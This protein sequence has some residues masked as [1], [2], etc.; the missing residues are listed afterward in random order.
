MV[1][2]F[3]T[4]FIREV[5]RQCLPFRPLIR[6]VEASE[7]KSIQRTVCFRF[8]IYDLTAKKKVQNVSKWH[9]Y[10]C[11]QDGGTAAIL[12][13]VQRSIRIRNI[14]IASMRRSVKFGTNWPSHVRDITVLVN[15]SWRQRRHLNWIEFK[16]QNQ[17]ETC[18]WPK[19]VD[20][21]NFDK[22]G[23]AMLEI[24]HLDL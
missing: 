4:K 12:D 3:P 13:R 5:C 18:L 22:I 24:L 21:L 6:S 9:V 16:G 15:Q 23:Q 10:V 7:Q 19:C 11:F 20:L 2:R 14:S 1:L 17:S 8:S